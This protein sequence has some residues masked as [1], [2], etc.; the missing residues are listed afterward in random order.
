MPKKSNKTEHV[1]NLISKN[2]EAI[3]QEDLQAEETTV[4]EKT[5][6]APEEVEVSLKPQEEEEKELKIE[7]KLKIELEPE[8]G[9]KPAAEDEPELLIQ[10][11]Q[12]AMEQTP[13]K[14]SLQEVDEASW[15]HLPIEEKR[16]YLVNL[17][18]KLALEMVDEVMERLN[19][20]TCPICKNDILAL[21]LNSLT[22]N[23]VT[24]DAGRQYMLLDVYRKQ[25][26]TD[27]VAALTKAC[28]RV[29]AA[30]KH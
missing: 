8:I 13:A 11:P 4:E 16:V 10:I 24:T 30:P 17:S 3:D 25:Y 12:E 9:I 1:L 28:V 15:P 20:C 18:E 5:T 26:E 2:D 19:V 7:R 23:Y 27:V 29:K 22:H 21:A 6:I 14:P